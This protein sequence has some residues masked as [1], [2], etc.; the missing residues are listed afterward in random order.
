M[1]NILLEKFQNITV[2]A[3]SLISSDDQQ[4]IEKIEDRFLNLRE[5]LETWKTHL[6][7]LADKMPGCNQY[8]YLKSDTRRDH[9]R[10]FMVNV[11]EYR[12]WAS[13]LFFS[14]AFSL[15]YIEETLQKIILERNKAIIDFFNTK[16]QLNVQVKDDEVDRL[17]EVNDVIDF[18]VTQNDGCG[19]VEA[20]ISNVIKTFK[21][22]FYKA[23]LVK[24]KIVFPR[25]WIQSRYDGNVDV[26]SDSIKIL[27]KGLELF[28]TGQLD[29][30]H[31][32]IINFLLDYH[33]PIKTGEKN[34]SPTTDKF[35]GIRLY[36]NHKCE[37]IFR[38]EEVAHHF[39]KMSY[40]L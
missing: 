5:N 20:G 14:P 18:L 1:K 29:K 21:K 31:T 17:A 35:K 25:V 30:P 9:S 4:E 13:R 8:Y 26:Y 39:F 2:D 6:N 36:K 28:E 32:G 16:Y 7:E 27:A 34:E 24:D 11:K 37:L 19:F 40:S 10:Y 23:A 15:V 38:D 33:N 3:V 22:S 12:D